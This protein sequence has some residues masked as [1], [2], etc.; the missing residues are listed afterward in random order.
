MSH[1]KA[2]FLMAWLVMAFLGISAAVAQAT[3]YT[4]NGGEGNWSVAGN[5]TPVTGPPNGY[6]KAIIPAGTVSID[7]SSPGSYSVSELT[8][9][10][11]ATLIISYYDLAL[12]SDNAEKT[13]LVT[14]NGSIQVINSSTYSRLY[15]WLGAIVTL[16]GGGEVV[17]GGNLVN[18]MENAGHGGS[19]IN[20]TSHT[21]RG[22]GYLAAGFTNKSQI[23]ADNGTLYL[24]APF[25]NTGAVIKAKGAGNALEFSSASLIGGDLLP[26]D[27][28]VILR[29]GGDELIDVNLGPG[30]VE[31]YGPNWHEFRGKITLNPGAKFTLN[32]TLRLSSA[33]DGTPVTFTNNALIRMQ[34]GEIYCSTGAT[35]T[36][37]GR[38]VMGGDLDNHIAGGDSSTEALIHGPNHT[39]EGGGTLGGYFT[40]NGTIK[41]NNGILKITGNIGGNGSFSV[42]DNATLFLSGSLT[43][44][45]FS[46][47]ALSSFF[48]GED[49]CK[50]CVLDLSGNYSFA[51]QDVTRLIWKDCSVLKMSGG[52][53]WQALEVGGKD[54]GT[55]IAGKTDNFALSHL[56]LEGTGTRAYLVDAVDN[57]RRSPGLKEALYTGYLMYDVLYQGLT[58]SPG[59]TLN[60]NGIHLY[61]RTGKQPLMRLVKAGEGAL[62]GGGTIIDVPVGGTIPVILPLLLD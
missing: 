36:G 43:S 22:G 21:I 41:A 35:L 7:S 20:D 13:C 61:T 26:R 27:G 56:K 33:P 9:G 44:G 51:Q 38:I 2:G 23:I 45:D 8:V 11:G 42:A 39:I 14:N 34:G 4:W 48:S 12:V 29:G 57:G 17:L 47:P 59:T 28:K 10:A 16:T 19:F 60:L 37:T 6:D 25:V 1:G 32:S 15:S 30:I 50:A 40:N 31:V 54:L 18:R 62:Y 49:Y 5:W 52:G 3:V 55:D 46:L 53:P 58:V 24:Q